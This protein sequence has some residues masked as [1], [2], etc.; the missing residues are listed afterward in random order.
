MDTH[1][2]GSISCFFSELERSKV[3]FSRG[4]FL[5][6]FPALA[7]FHRNVSFAMPCSVDVDAWLPVVDYS[8]SVIRNL[9][10]ARHGRSTAILLHTETYLSKSQKKERSTVC[11][12]GDS[13]ERQK[14]D[15]K[16][17]GQNIISLASS[18]KMMG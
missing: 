1:Q 7:Y 13:E 10:E 6:K 11:M 8:L 14:V 17:S 12:K 18:M 2:L 3:N 9:C 4:N 5:A 15:I 16:R